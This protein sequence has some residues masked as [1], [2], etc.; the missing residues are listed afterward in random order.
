MRTPPSSPITTRSNLNL[1]PIRNENSQNSPRS[2]TQQVVHRSTT[3]Q[4]HTLSSLDTYC[5]PSNEMQWGLCITFCLT[6]FSFCVSLAVG[7]ASSDE[8]TSTRSYAVAAASVF[9][10][11]L[12]LSG[13]AYSKCLNLVTLTSNN[14]NT[15]HTTSTESLSET[16]PTDDETIQLLTETSL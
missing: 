13:Y 14:E 12:I 11:I 16:S 9:S 4:I 10:A 15:Q 8:G 5:L 1:D 6:L 7:S 2:N 3:N